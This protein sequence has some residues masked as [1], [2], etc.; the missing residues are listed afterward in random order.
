[1]NL[2]NNVVF[3]IKGEGGENLMLKKDINT[4]LNKEIEWSKDKNNQLKNDI[5][6]EQGEWFVKGLEQAKLLINSME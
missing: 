2:S 4:V 5:T 1:L 3:Q 6:D